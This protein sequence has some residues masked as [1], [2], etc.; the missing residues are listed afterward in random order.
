ML[1]RCCTDSEACF[2]DSSCNEMVCPDTSLLF[3][4]TGSDD[5]VAR[6]RLSSG[7]VVNINGDN[8]TLG[9]DTLPTGVAIQ[10]HDAVGT[11]LANYSLT[12][13]IERASI[14]TGNAVICVDGG[15]SPE[16]DQA[17]CP[18][19]AG[20]CSTGINAVHFY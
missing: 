13:A 7:E 18:V 17:M 5:S 11:G 9:G 16:T 4:I 14:L 10:S 8:T 2:N 6:V 20:I 15:L 12:L 1:C 3:T 19:G